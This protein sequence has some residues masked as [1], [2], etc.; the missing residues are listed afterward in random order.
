VTSDEVRARIR[1]HVIAHFHLGG[2]RELGDEDSLLDARVID[3]LGILDLV[4]YLE[5]SFGIEVTDEELTPENFE[6]IGALARF[7]SRRSARR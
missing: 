4:G 5:E 3:S 1:S 2:M 7:V 6:S